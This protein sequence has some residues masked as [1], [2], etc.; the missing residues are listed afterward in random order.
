ME[1]NFFALLHF[2]TW[3]WLEEESALPWGVEEGDLTLYRTTKLVNGAFTQRYASN[4]ELIYPG[5]C[6]QSLL[7][8]KYM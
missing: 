1:E 5:R 8:E 2:G 6:A 3:K 4:V 7:W